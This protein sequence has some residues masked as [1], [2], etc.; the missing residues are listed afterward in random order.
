[1]E[2][3]NDI[4][5]NLVKLSP[6]KPEQVVT[7]KVPAPDYPVDEVVDQPGLEEVALEETP[8]YSAPAL[9]NID[10]VEKDDTVNSLPPEER[11]SCVLFEELYSTYD[12]SELLEL[13]TDIMQIQGAAIFLLKCFKIFSKYLFPGTWKN[14][15]ISFKMNLS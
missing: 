10:L 8:L 9:T 2:S 5:D 13:N 11:V 15:I 12:S 6:V 3:G 14:Y 1:M 7:T 4:S